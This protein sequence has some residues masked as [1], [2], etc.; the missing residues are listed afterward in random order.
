[1]SHE[2]VAAV[3][4]AL[5]ILGVFA[6]T[7]QQLTLAEIA[8]RTKLYKSTILRLSKS[9]ERFGYLRRTES[10]AYQL[11]SKVLYLGNLYQRHF[12]TADWVPQTL[13]RI[14]AELHEGASFYVRDGE[15][16]VCL[17]RVESSRAIRD[18][19][20]EGDRLSLTVGA[21]GHVIRAF[22][23]LAGARFDQVRREM[24]SA[25]VGERDPE[26]AAVAC[27]AFGVGQKFMG[28]LSVSG[29]KYRIEALGIEQILPVLFRNASELTRVLGGDP[30]AFPVITAKRR[31]G[32]SREAK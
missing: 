13:R 7:D 24:Y 5:S 8:G 9:L 10:G 16:R 12:R 30:A 28:A 25:S 27:P 14:V 21:S 32:K 2:G 20:H 15:Y 3:D 23:G 19:V 29:P 26:T 6:D 4:R 11:G 17:H 31:K 18:A 1:M 22:D